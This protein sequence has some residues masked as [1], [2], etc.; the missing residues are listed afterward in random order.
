M[1]NKVIYKYLDDRNICALTAKNFKKK[2]GWFINYQKAGMK[3]GN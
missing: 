3:I 2:D 1:V